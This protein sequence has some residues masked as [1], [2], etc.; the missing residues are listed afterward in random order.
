[1]QGK[2]IRNINIKHI[3]NGIQNL[4]GIPEVKEVMERE[5]VDFIICNFMFFLKKI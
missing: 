4:L 3:I 1:M 2:N 5:Q